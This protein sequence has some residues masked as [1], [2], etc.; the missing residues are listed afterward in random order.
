MTR[1][2]KKEEG[3]RKNWLAA[4]FLAV[5]SLPLVQSTLA[6]P[7]EEIPKL[8]PP[9][10]EIP[11]T[12]WEQ[13]GVTVVLG[14]L[15]LLGVL[16]LLIRRLARPLPKLDTPPEARARW[17]LEALHSKPED[18]EL[19]SRVSQIVRHYFGAVFPLPPGE[20]TTMEFCRAADDCPAIGAELATAA[21]EFLRECDRR[22]FASAPPAGEADA[23]ARALALVEKGEARRAQFYAAP[24]A[25]TKPA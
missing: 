14:S 15:V 18:G 10:A 6:Q 25:A 1:R 2:R 5:C 24:I 22:K 9:H 17:A 8:Q 11:P 20:L 21:G 16:G 23:V 19:L 13:Y 12:F 7:A 3:R 4:I